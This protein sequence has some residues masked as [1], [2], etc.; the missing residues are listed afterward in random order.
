MTTAAEFS[1]LGIHVTD[2]AR[3]E[4]FYTRVLGLLVSVIWFRPAE[5][6]PTPTARGNGASPAESQPTAAPSSTA[7]AADTSA[8]ESRPSAAEPPGTSTP[9]VA[10]EARR[11][12]GPAAG[13][14]ALKVT[15]ARLCR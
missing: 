6:T 11:S 9:P 2:L 10:A 1:H 8:G 13:A 7:A 3:M 5:E 4:D 15:S 12:S 14:S